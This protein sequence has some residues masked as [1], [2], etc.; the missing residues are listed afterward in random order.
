M[1][2]ST[3]EF[4]I[5]EVSRAIKKI[6]DSKNEPKEF[7]KEEFSSVLKKA[8]E[9]NMGIDLVNRKKSI[10]HC[11]KVYWLSDC[12]IYDNYDVDM[13]FKSA[14]SDHVRKVINTSTMKY[15]KNAKK[16]RDDGDEEKTHI[17]IRTSEYSNDLL[18][19]FEKYYYGVTINQI[20]NYLNN[21]LK[22]YTDKTPCNY[23]YLMDFIQM[24]GDE[25]IDQLNN[26]STVS[27][28]SMDVEYGA[29]SDDF[30]KF[31]GV[32]EG[33]RDTL[34]LIMKRKGRSKKDTISKNSV[35]TF[36]KDYSDKNI[37]RRIRVDGKGKNGCIQID[38]EIIKLKKEI[39]VETSADTS[40]V[41]DKS[42]FDVV[43]KVL[44]KMKEE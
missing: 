11:N 18:C 5:I 12:E 17:C 33:Y 3:V 10:S 7:T 30:M 38:T 26:M 25:F 28:L 29:L 9:H 19:V 34:Q 15:N 35:Q 1:S 21:I 41:D 23:I 40:E 36:F 13:V 16:G 37:V 22:E 43:N 14:K 42:F 20:K 6:T 27:C 8:L 44:S 32:G 24:P 4:Y 39:D 2:K 31:S